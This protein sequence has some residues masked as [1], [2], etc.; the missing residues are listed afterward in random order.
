MIAYVRGTLTEKTPALAVIEAGGVGYELHIPLSSYDRL[1]E[2]GQEVKLLT[3]HYV[4]EDNQQLFGFATAE[5]KGLFERMLA[6]S[7][8]GPRLA[9]G[10]LS[11]LSVR[12]FKAAVV[13]GDVKR[14]SSISGIGKKT[15]ERM[16][17]ELKDKISG[18]EALEALASGPGGAIDVRLRDTVLALVSLGYKQADAQKMLKGLVDTIRPDDTVEDLVR[19]ALTG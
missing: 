19:K 8:I 12:E 5:E 16:V 3:H 17:I 2:P 13:E 4:R 6:V 18:G 14:L 15:A 9:L 11:G 1:P 10:A 7:G